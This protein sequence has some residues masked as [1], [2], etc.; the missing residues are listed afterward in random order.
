MYEK[1]INN[2]QS[3]IIGKE[4]VLHRLLIGLLSEGHILIEDVPGVGKTT[5]AQALA[6]SMDL[7]FS[8]VQFTPDL[9]PSDIL[10]VSVYRR[11]TYDFV[12]NK[13]PIFNQI[14]LADEINRASPPKTQSSL[15]EA[16]EERQVTMDG[17]T[18]SFDGP[19]MVIAT[20]NPIEYEGTF[21][22][23]EAQL[24]RFLMKIR[25]GYPE[26]ADEMKIVERM[27]TRQDISSLETVLTVDE[28]KKMQSIVKDVHADESIWAYIVDIV[29][30]TRASDEVI[31]GCSPRAAVGLL[32]AAKARAFINN[33]SYVIPEDVRE[34]AVNV[35]AH[36]LIVKPEIRYKGRTSDH[37]IGDLIEFVKVPKVVVHDE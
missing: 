24:D 21:P 27:G 29:R 28:V 23:P 20:Q 2:M 4:A 36:R 22:L 7:S 35:L 16:M 5:A 19:F 31:L 8:R 6:K 14:V 37:I 33:R 25:I 13:G 30:K 10:G 26:K 12:F 15:L 1:L 11:D 18:Y 32:T 9:L 3:I 17:K 34:L